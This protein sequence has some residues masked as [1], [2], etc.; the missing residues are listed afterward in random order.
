MKPY[1]SYNSFERFGEKLRIALL[2]LLLGQIFYLNISSVKIPIPSLIVDKI[3]NDFLTIPSTISIRTHG[4][5][6]SGFSNIQIS[7]IEFAQENE[8]FAKLEGLEVDLNPRFLADNNEAAFRNIQLSTIIID[9]KS[10]FKELLTGKNFKLSSKNKTSHQ[11]SG[12]L[13]L[14]QHEIKILGKLSLPVQTN[15]RSD[16]AYSIGD[17][18]ELAEQKTAMAFKYSESL[19]RMSLEALLNFSDDSMHLYLRQINDDQKHLIDNAILISKLEFGTKKNF[20]LK[21]RADSVLIE[22]KKQNFDFLRPEID[23]EIDLSEDFSIP[24]LPK[25][26]ICTKQVKLGGKLE[27]TLPAF[28]LQSSDTLNKVTFMS[29]DKGLAASTSSYRKDG[30][31]LHRGFLNIN[32]VHWNLLA[33]LPQGTMKVIDGNSLKIRL[34]ENFSPI[35]ENSLSQFFIHADDFSALETP[36]GNFRFIGEAGGDLSINIHHAYGKFGS[37]QAI[38][39]YTQSWNPAK[40]RFLVKGNCTPSDIEN[41]LG[42]WWMPLFADCSFND[43]APYGDF[44]I[45]GI[46]GGKPGNSQTYGSITANDLT[47]RDCHINDAQIDVLV[48]ENSTELRTKQISHSL[49]SLSGSLLFPHNRLNSSVLL[50]FS[51]SGNFPLNDARKVFGPSIEDTL[52]GIDIPIINCNGSG[53]IFRDSTT[54]IS[55]ANFSHFNIGIESVVPIS[56]H[57]IPIRSLSGNIESEKGITKGHFPKVEIANGSGVLLFEELSRESDRIKIKFNLD[58]ADRYQLINSLQR[59]DLMDHKQKKEN[60]SAPIKDEKINKDKLAGKLNLSLLAEGPASDPLQFKGSGICILT[61]VE[62]GNINFL[63]GIRSKLGAFNLPLPSD[64][65]SFNRLEAPFHLDHEFMHFDKINLSGPL[66][67]LTAKG[68]INIDSEEVDLMA[69]LKIA[70]NLNIPI[71]KQLVNFADPFPKMSTIKISGPWDNP[72]WR[73]HISPDQ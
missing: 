19:P 41:W 47:F 27:G 12:F 65:L 21:A 30:Y 70:G 59:A 25:A 9:F 26:R 36:P 48:E 66:S 46:W 63:G 33:K 42:T 2:L 62:V 20:Y 55:D 68:S 8:V 32:P 51:V 15:E 24:T 13:A 1:R 31:M 16:S 45:S 52:K 57:G 58:N 50:E 71:V 69:D 28:V 67:L 37:S 49:G 35:D 44:S 39:S 43:S 5:Y 56:Y 18:L 3:F 38:G 73:I 4:S 17:L 6:L 64:A 22:G 60:I 29:D 14:G 7:K 23:L 54:L 10:E 11:V 72:D 34:S 61:D 53:K 40:F